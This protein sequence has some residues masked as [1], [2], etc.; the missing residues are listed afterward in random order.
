MEYCQAVPSKLTS[1]NLTGPKLTT[2]S[3]ALLGLLNLQPFS[4][5]ELTKYMK[6]SAL[7][8]LWPRTEAS[9][10][11]EPKVLEAHGY[12]TADVASTGAR[13]RTVYSITPAGRRALRAWL[14]EPG[15]TLVFECEAALKA[16]FGDVTDLEA[17][18][19]QLEVLA[20]RPETSTP[21]PLEVLSAFREGRMHF[22]D[23]LHYTVMAA[24]LIAHV[25]LAV[26]GWAESWLQRT[27]SWNGTSLDEPKRVEAVAVLDELAARLAR[28]RVSGRRR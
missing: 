3:Y 24:D 18:R 1:P 21:P 20:A 14:R 15:G 7:A 22:P 8:H 25:N 5:Y 9:L 11:K 27:E 19:A 28:R 6:R 12:A 26:A 10:Y 4:A 13:A 16:F 2:T 17:L 23:R